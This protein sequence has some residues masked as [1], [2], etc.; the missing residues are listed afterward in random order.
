MQCESVGKSE[1]KRMNPRKVTIVILATLSMAFA[2]ADDFKTINGKEYKDATVSHVEPDGIVVKTKS[3]ISKI[4]FTE[5]PKELQQRFNYE[6]EKAA[7][8]S[9]AVS[10]AYEETAKQ[11]EQEMRQK[12]EQFG[13]QQAT[14]QQNVDQVRNV[15][16]LQEHHFALQ[17]DE[18]ILSSE[19]A[20]RQKLPEQLS[21]RSKTG[22]SGPRRDRHFRY[23]NPARA[24]LPGL[25]TQLTA[26]RKEILG[27]HC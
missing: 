5:L 20:E 13:K 9:A 23:D 15:Q 21:V 24:D 11:Q 2:L 10:T 27:N 26:V 8:Y 16:A 6:P 7:A 1:S 18:A 25:Q 3:G 14:I 12:A 4:Y 22:N 17:Q 19:I